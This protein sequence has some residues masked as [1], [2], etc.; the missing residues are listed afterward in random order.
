MD[1]EDKQDISEIS[2]QIQKKINFFFQKNC[3]IWLETIPKILNI[4]CSQIKTRINHY[5][6]RT[7]AWLILDC[8]YRNRKEEKNLADFKFYRTPEIE[9]KFRK[10]R[11]LSAAKKNPAGNVPNLAVGSRQAIR[12][13]N[14]RNQSDWH[15]TGRRP[16]NARARHGEW[17][18]A[19]GKGGSSRAGRRRGHVMAKPPRLIW[20]GSRRRRHVPT[21]SPSGSRPR[22][23]PL[24]YWGKISRP[25]LG[26][27]SLDLGERLYPGGR[28]EKMYVL[29]MDMNCQRKRCTRKNWHDRHEKRPAWKLQWLNYYYVSE[30]I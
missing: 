28:L 2:D 20:V 18:Q 5:K 7:V 16:G 12:G 9:R 24:Y 3:R 26:V 11:W 17:I 23:R 8:L 29:L 14:T 13:S 15:G 22:R 10:Y 6:C 25:A 21:A 1:K 30:P 4:T 19:G 27:W